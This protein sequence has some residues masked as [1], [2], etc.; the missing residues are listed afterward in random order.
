ML[1]VEKSKTNSF[2]TTFGFI[3]SGEFFTLYH[4]RK[5]PSNHFQLDL[6][7]FRFEGSQIQGSGGLMYTSLPRLLP[8]KPYDNQYNPFIFRP[9]IGAPLAP[10]YQARGSGSTL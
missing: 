2:H 10:T 4:Y 9:F 6:W 1:D 7:D 3:F 8:G 5:S